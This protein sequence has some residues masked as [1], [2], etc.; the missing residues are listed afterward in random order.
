MHIIPL[1]MTIIVICPENIYKRILS[2][3]S[4]FV[5]R[6]HPYYYLQHKLISKK[7]CFIFQLRGTPYYS[8]KL[9]PGPCSSVGEMRGTDTQTD[10]HASPLYISRRLRPTRNAIS[11]LACYSKIVL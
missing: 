4:T 5:L 8:P 2:D 3:L 10:R 11:I 7:V 1:I 6:C 9:H